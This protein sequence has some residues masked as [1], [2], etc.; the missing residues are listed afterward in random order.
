MLKANI[1]FYDIEEFGYFKRGESQPAF[2]GLEAFF[3]DFSNWLKGQSALGSTL[4]QDPRPSS[5]VNGNI[6]CKDFYRCER[7]GDY[8]L[9]LWNEVSNEDGQIL[10]MPKDSKVGEEEYN[11][12]KSNAG[13]ILGLPS[14]YWFIKDLNAFATIRFSHSLQSVSAVQ[15][16]LKEYAE[17]MSGFAITNDEGRIVGYEG[18][19]NERARWFRFNYA[20]MLNKSERQKLLD[21]PEKVKALIRRIS[22]PKIIPDRRNDERQLLTQLQQAVNKISQG[23]LKSSDDKKGFIDRFNKIASDAGNQNIEVEIPFV[24]DQEIME[25][26]IQEFDKNVEELKEEK[27]GFKVSGYG[28]IWLG[29]QT[30]KKEIDLSVSHTKQKLPTA[31]EVMEAI[32]QTRPAIMLEVEQRDLVY[33]SAA[34]G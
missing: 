15:R 29:D 19:G 21:N 12:P 5:R 28:N 23:W 14:Y 20:K 11:K 31:S 30:I 13:D 26:L 7:S 10:A 18:G 8:L 22:V 16:Y 1:H 25:F 33:R 4:V 32:N 34:N 27:I 9:I 6:Y 3:S 24:G 17:T 2:G